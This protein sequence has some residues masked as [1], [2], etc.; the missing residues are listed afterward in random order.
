[1]NLGST[2]HV[3]VTDR[4]WTWALTSGLSAGR[5]CPVTDAGQATRRGRQELRCGVGTSTDLW[6]RAYGL[7]AALFNFARQR[8]V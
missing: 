7:R 6:Q 1:M 4:L 3:P 2:F 8:T 5:G